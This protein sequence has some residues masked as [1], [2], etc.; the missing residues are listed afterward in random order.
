MGFNM[1]EKE[2][3]SIFCRLEKSRLG[4]DLDKEVIQKIIIVYILEYKFYK[5]S[6]FFIF[7]EIRFMEKYN[8]LK[9]NK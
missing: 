4:W 5:D 9:I 6:I 3:Y 1:G 7:I 8:M 2:V